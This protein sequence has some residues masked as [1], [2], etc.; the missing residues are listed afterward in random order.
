[1]GGEDMAF[2]RRDDFW[3]IDKLAPNAKKPH[4]RFS[5]ERQTREVEVAG[6]GV[7]GDSKLTLTLRGG[8][9]EESTY[10]PLSNPLIRKVTVRRF[11]G[12]YDFYKSFRKAALL[13]Y[14]V[15]AEPSPF[16]PFYSYMPQ[17]SQMSREQ[18]NYYFYL[19]SEIRK[20]NYSLKS[21]V[22]YLYLYVYEI[23]NLPE[24]I[25]AKEGIVL[26]CEL[27]RCYRKQI[28]AI[29][30]YFSVWVQDYCIVHRLDAPTAL[31]ED[32][33]YDIIDATSFKEFYL[34]GVYSKNAGEI[35]ALLSCLSDY[36]WRTGRY[37]GGA[38]RDMYKK[39]IEGAMLPVLRSLWENGA[40]FLEDS[41]VERL[42]R[43]AFPCSLCTHSVK[44]RIE[45]E[46][47]PLGRS[48]GLRDRVTSA[49]KYV[50]NCLRAALSV[51]SRLAVKH[52]HEDDKLLIDAY[53]AEAFRLA[54]QKRRE[55][56]REAYESLY[57]APRQEMSFAG[58]ESIEKS[59]WQNTW[60][61]VDTEESE[62][63]KNVPAQAEK[64]VE[65]PVQIIETEPA[66]EEKAS[67]L[68]QS[69]ESAPQC[70]FLRAA[71]LGDGEAMRRA[72]A[73]AFLPAETLAERINEIFIDRIGDIVFEI[74]DS[75]V[76][77]IEDYREE[78]SEWLQTQK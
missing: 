22:S 42:S 14:D 63:Q 24:K 67:P 9:S 75:G 34:G 55:A 7:S 8:E 40:L 47:Y 68:P 12:G 61:L 44:C 5:S 28:G 3:D 69:N 18:K 66:F 17:Y 43:D 27:W 25:P 19:R 2:D 73:D 29:D 74:A 38:D 37:A 72:A 35:T 48:D 26:L 52:L 76:S 21:D 16:V 53:F 4:P 32:F 1:M 46:Y 54:N 50:E 10:V 6:D 59:S 64:T 20:G 51:K 11:K 70:A 30:R 39:H 41:A 31:L 23:L 56:Q 15:A 62:A 13:Y 58:A 65:A 71:L 45:I 33:I 57:D 78:V 60:L 49:L 36:D 77:L